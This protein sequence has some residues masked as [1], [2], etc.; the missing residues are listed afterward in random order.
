MYSVGAAALLVRLR[1]AG[2][3]DRSTLARAFRT[4]ARN[5]RKSEPEPLEVPGEEGRHEIPRRLE[6]LRCRALAEEFIGWSKVC[7][8]LQKPLADIEQGLDGP[9]AGD[10]DGR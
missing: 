9:A 5:W 10:V 3:I 6:R 8:L 1:Q 2:V 7:K 4:F